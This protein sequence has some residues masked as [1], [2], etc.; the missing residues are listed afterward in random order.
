MTGS[1]FGTAAV[2]ATAIG[3]QS[4]TF[5]NQFGVNPQHWVS[6]DPFTNIPSTPLN[7]AIDNQEANPPAILNVRVPQNFT[8][9]RRSLQV[10]FESE[11]DDQHKVQFI[12]NQEP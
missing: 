5:E 9:Q 4:N 3:S 12:I 6:Y 10:I 7:A 1:P 11:W 2:Q 8:G